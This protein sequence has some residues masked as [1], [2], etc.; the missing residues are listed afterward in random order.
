MIPEL[1]S[2]EKISKSFGVSCREFDVLAL[3][4]ITGI[5]PWNWFFSIR[6]VSNAGENHDSR[7]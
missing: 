5:I 4:D 3:I 2:C 6:A 7:A 1:G